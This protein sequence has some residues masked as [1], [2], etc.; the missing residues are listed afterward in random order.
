MNYLGYEQKTQCENSDN[1]KNYY[2]NLLH[3]EKK[4][5]YQLLPIISESFNTLNISAFGS[6]NFHFSKHTHFDLQIPHTVELNQSSIS[7]ILLFNLSLSLNSDIHIN[8]Y[9]TENNE[10]IELDIATF[11]QHIKDPYLFYLNSISWDVD[12]KIE[13]NLNFTTGKN[14]IEV[15]FTFYTT[16]IVSASLRL[17]NYSN[18]EYDMLIQSGEHDVTGS[19][20][21]A[22]ILNIFNQSFENKKLILM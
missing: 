6:L 5:P 12:N 22:A 19:N 1:F 8:F 21:I 7:E 3:K 4:F 14:Y 11:E 9:N 17:P 10:I 15:T 2:E 16:D 20:R 18:E 13:L